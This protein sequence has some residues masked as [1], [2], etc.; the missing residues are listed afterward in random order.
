LPAAAA[1]IGFSRHDGAA[2]RTHFTL[3]GLMHVRAWPA[4][5]IGAVVRDHAELGTALPSPFVAVFVVS[6]FASLTLA[7]GSTA[8]LSGTPL[9]VGR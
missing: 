2:S 6:S 8:R 4:V 5:G 3:F 1:E 7:P 9:A